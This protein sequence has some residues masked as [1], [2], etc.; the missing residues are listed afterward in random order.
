MRETIRKF[1]YWRLRVLVCLV[2]ALGFMMA[3][4]GLATPHNTTRVQTLFAQSFTGQHAVQLFEQSD[5]S[6]GEV[7]VVVLILTTCDSPLGCIFGN[8]ELAPGQYTISANGAAVPGPINV[9]LQTFSFC[10]EPPSTLEVTVEDLTWTAFGQAFPG[11]LSSHALSPSG[12]WS[13]GSS[14]TMEREAHATGFISGGIEVD[15]AGAEFASIGKR[16]DQFKSRN[17]R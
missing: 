6:S 11:H 10:G 7:N 8:V 9:T 5:A 17:S 16:Q 12:G 15:F 1:A 2:P 4:L 13:S 3:R 14:R